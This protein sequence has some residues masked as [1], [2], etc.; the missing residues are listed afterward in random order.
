MSTVY[1][2]EDDG[3]IREIEEYALTSAGMQVRSFGTVRELMEEISSIIPD[4]LILDIMLPDGDG[5]EVVR[6]LR[7]NSQYAEL[8]I[9]L[10]TAKTR[11][12][13][14]VRGLDFGADDYIT[15]PFS[16]LEFTSRVKSLLR[17]TSSGDGVLEFD[18]LKM[19][20]E[21][22]A[23]IINDEQIALT[24]KEFDLL[25]LMLEN[26]EKVLSRHTILEKVW[27]FEFEGESRTIDMHIKTLRQKLGAWSAHIITVREVG[28]AVKSL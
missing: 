21:K 3:S 11:E 18:G 6:Q 22:H 28:Y 7:A 13:D 15:K 24:T 14:I 4:L 2:A 20:V 12:I 19:D 8:P 17:R 16:V 5:M 27:G 26:R 9:I 10:V 23:V 1:I 25:K